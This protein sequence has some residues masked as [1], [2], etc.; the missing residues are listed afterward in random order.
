MLKI[1]KWGQKHGI[2][3]IFH[4]LLAY[5]HLERNVVFLFHILTNNKNDFFMYGIAV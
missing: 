2:Y 3:Y 5:I 4:K 1:L